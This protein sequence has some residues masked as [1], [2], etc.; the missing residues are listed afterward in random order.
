MRITTS[1]ATTDT[2]TPITLTATLPGAPVSGSVVFFSENGWL[3]SASLAGNRASVSL[4]LSAGV[5]A[6]SAL[7]Q[8]PGNA[9][10]S[11]VVSEVVDV[12]LVCD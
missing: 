10:D 5:H 9:V 11:P 6:L 3:G 12:P 7:L 8:I 2:Q 4:T 1:N